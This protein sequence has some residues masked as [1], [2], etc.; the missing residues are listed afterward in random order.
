MG[1]QGLAEMNWVPS[2][3][4][5][6]PPNSKAAEHRTV[7]GEETRIEAICPIGDTSMVDRVSGWWLGPGNGVVKWGYT[8]FL[9]VFMQI[10]WGYILFPT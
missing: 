2:K 8:S 6:A 5:R 1:S 7:G 3:D 10:L 9:F 4:D